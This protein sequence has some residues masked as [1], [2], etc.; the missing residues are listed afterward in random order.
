MVSIS[1]ASQVTP[2][3]RAIWPNAPRG[4]RREFLEPGPIIEPGPAP[5]PGIMVGLA[6]KQG[7]RRGSAWAPRPQPERTASTL[8]SRSG[9]KKSEWTS[10]LSSSPHDYTARREL[11]CIHTWWRESAA[12]DDQCGLGA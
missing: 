1:S 11:P 6:S 4:A 2:V 7:A 10:G 8:G 5:Y 9:P 12:M 3:L